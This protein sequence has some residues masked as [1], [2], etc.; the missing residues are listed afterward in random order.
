M[1]QPYTI[2]ERL[3]VTEKGSRLTEKENKYVF[4]VDPDSNRSEIKDAVEKLFRVKVVKVNT[5]NRAGKAKR[6]RRGRPGRTAAWK[7]AVVTLKE[8]DKIEAT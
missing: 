1:K 7:Q 8:G 2:I 3:R 4:I 5:L 6:D